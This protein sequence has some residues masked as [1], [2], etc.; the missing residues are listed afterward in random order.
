M[1]DISPR[2]FN[3]RLGMALF[4][5]YLVFYLGFVLVSAFAADWMEATVLGGLNLAIVYGFGLIL[6]AFVLAMIYGWGC[7]SDEEP[8]A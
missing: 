7:R 8:R 3:S 4:A 5:L 6:L 1:H 2:R